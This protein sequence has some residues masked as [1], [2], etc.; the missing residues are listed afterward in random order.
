MFV[1]TCRFGK[2]IIIL[3]AHMHTQNGFEILVGEHA[4]F[5]Q[6]WPGIFR[7]DDFRKVQKTFQ[8]FILQPLGKVFQTFLPIVEVITLWVHWHKT[9]TLLPSSEGYVITLGVH[10]HK[11]R[12]LLPSSEG[13]VITLGVHWHKTRTLLP[14]SEG[15]VITL[16]VH[17]HKTRTLLPSSEGYY[18]NNGAINEWKF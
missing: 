5:V 13:Y 15:Y 3:N 12:T 2:L 10:R 9:R 14:S 18:V 17:W 8:D 11:T 7:W 16:G 4:W 6:N 1:N